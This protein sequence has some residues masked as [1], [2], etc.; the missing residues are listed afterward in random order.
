VWEREEEKERDQLA[1]GR[2]SSRSRAGCRG[3]ATV[4]CSP[5]PPF[6]VTRL[7]VQSLPRAAAQ[8]GAPRFGS[9]RGATT[10]HGTLCSR[11]Q[12]LHTEWFACNARVSIH[13]ATA[14]VVTQCALHRPPS[15]P[16]IRATPTAQLGAWAVVWGPS[17]SSR[18]AVQTAV[19]SR[20]E[21]DLSV[22]HNQHMN[23]SHVQYSA[24]YDWRVQ[25]S[26]VIFLSSSV[27][28]TVRKNAVI[29]CSS[30]KRAETSR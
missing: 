17:S 23:V 27:E 7:Y 22:V 19:V 18:P 15:R 28:K 8:P 30:G 29:F 13:D 4:T 6:A 20:E 25:F 9:I 14:D 12:R 5:W 2:G 10:T 26:K 24:A 11:A 21:V 1:A 16:L 3:T